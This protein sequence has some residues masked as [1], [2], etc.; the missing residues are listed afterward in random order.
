M[1]ERHDAREEKRDE[2]R[3]K[4]KQKSN[5]V[6]AEEVDDITSTFPC[7]QPQ[8][9]ERGLRLQTFTGLEAAE[10][11]GTQP[12]SSLSTLTLKHVRGFQLWPIAEFMEAGGTTTTPGGGCQKL[13]SS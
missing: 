1:L 12:Q 6:A 4:R 10:R 2:R 7:S 13:T 11:R 5:R 9:S 3:R 8:K